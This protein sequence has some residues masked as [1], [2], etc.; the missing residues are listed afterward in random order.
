ML[1]LETGELSPSKESFLNLSSPTPQCSL[2]LL[3]SAAQI[4]IVFI[5][6]RKSSNLKSMFK[7]PS[8]V[9][10]QLYQQVLLPRW[11]GKHFRKEM[12]NLAPRIHLFI[13]CMN[14]GLQLSYLLASDQYHGKA[15]PAAAARLCHAHR[16]RGICLPGSPCSGRSHPPPVPMPPP[17][18]NEPLVAPSYALPR[19]GGTCWC[20]FASAPG[21]VSPLLPPLP[22]PCYGTACDDGKHGAFCFLE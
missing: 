13:S 1:G 18:P 20:P 17:P 10:A 22:R 21:A 14:K 5:Q 16:S 9:D 7:S 15:K 4:G 12:A 6:L 2:L 19:L 11:P 8:L 3:W